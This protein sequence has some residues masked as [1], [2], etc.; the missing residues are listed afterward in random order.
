[1]GSTTPRAN[2]PFPGETDTFDVAADIEALANA[3]D[4]GQTVL[5]YENTFSSAPPS[6]AFTIPAIP[7][8]CRDL[9]INITLKDTKTVTDTWT[10][11]CYQFNGDAGSNYYYGYNFFLNFGTGSVSYGS[12]GPFSNT[13]DGIVAASSATGLSV[14]ASCYAQNSILIPNYTDATKFKTGL[15]QNAVVATAASAV[16]ESGAIVYATTQP[17][18][19]ITLVPTANAVGIAAGSVIRVY[20]IG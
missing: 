1:M 20:G 11:W 18:N 10:K 19:S 6:G 9:R 16:W 15:F 2:L 3:A 14:L 12:G 4:A 5:L 7:Q 13:A 8:T 17:I